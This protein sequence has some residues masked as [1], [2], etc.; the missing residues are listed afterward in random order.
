MAQVATKGKLQPIHH[1]LARQN[2]HRKKPPTQQHFL[3]TLCA[4]HGKPHLRLPINPTLSNRL[5]TASWLLH[6][7][8]DL[9]AGINTFML[10][11]SLQMEVQS[12][13]ELIAL[14]NMASQSAGATFQDLQMVASTN[15]NVSI[16]TNH[17]FAKFDLQRSEMLMIMYWVA[18]EVTSAIAQFLGDYERHLHLLMDYRPTAPGHEALVPGLVLRYFQVHKNLWI[19]QQLVSDSL[20]LFPS[21]VHDIWTQ[22][23]LHSHI[24]EWPFP[25]RYITSVAPLPGLGNLAAPGGLVYGATTNV[26]PMAAGGPPVAAALAPRVQEICNQT[27]M[28]KHSRSTAH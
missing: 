11:G 12:Q 27:A 22:L 3:E 26:L 24:W 20:I 14:Y 13:E 6:D 19:H 28:T 18:N 16:P 2:L 4:L 23:S 10:G 7:I 9:L 15:R 17:T 5:S 25:M 1:E 21:G 8:N